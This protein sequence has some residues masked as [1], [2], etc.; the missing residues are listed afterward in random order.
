MSDLKI[1]DITLLNEQEKNRLITSE[2]LTYA[3]EVRKLILNGCEATPD[4][5][6]NITRLELSCS[7]FQQLDLSQNTKLTQLELTDCNELDGISFGDQCPLRSLTIRW[8]E[9]LSRLDIASLSELRV[10]ELE[11][12][13][14][15]SSIEFGE[16]SPVKNFTR[17][18]M[19]SLPW[20]DLK[21][22]PKLTGLSIIDEVVEN[23]EDFNIQHS[24]TLQS[25]CVSIEELDTEL[26]FS[27]QS[28]LELSL[29]AYHAESLNLTECPKLSRLEL[30]FSETIESLN[31]EIH[32]QL[33]DLIIEDYDALKSIALHPESK[34]RYIKIKNCDD[35]QEITHLQMMDDG[36]KDIR[37][38]LD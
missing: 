4:L 25:L 32:N 22:T 1:S 34:L 19:M 35:L 12:C 23:I 24:K 2:G 33:S 5:F 11:E 29:S 37:V 10:L 21:L 27:C 17:R 7:P 3:S 36:E 15:L 9:N 13:E 16:D 18:N 6:P 14:Q 28:L 38:S 30:V 31:L 8:C 20:L 26:N